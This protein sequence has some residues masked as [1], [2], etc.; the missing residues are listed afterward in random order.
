MNM[1]GFS[2]DLSVH[3]LGGGYVMTQVNATA[4]GEALVK[5]QQLG[6]TAIALVSYHLD[7]GQNDQ[8]GGPCFGPG[9]KTCQL[10]VCRLNPFSR[11][12]PYGGYSCQVLGPVTYPGCIRDCYVPP[13]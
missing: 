10:S 11:T 4:Q 5:P 6:T 7:C 1:P 2:A 9:P 12:P 3:Q 8:F 13:R